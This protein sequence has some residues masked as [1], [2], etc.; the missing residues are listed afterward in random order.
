MV[1][2]RLSQREDALCQC[3]D[4]TEPGKSRCQSCADANNEANRRRRHKN[5]EVKWKT[6]NQNAERKGKPVRPN[7][8]HAAQIYFSCLQ[9]LCQPHNKAK[10]HLDFTDYSA[11]PEL[12]QPGPNVVTRMEL[13]ERVAVL[14]A[15]VAELKE[16]AEIGFWHKRCC[17]SPLRECQDDNEGD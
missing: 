4:P 5:P 7:C 12:F 2:V 17:A 10:G 13:E 3:G 11:H 15:E 14:E 1:Y 9:I 8:M 16:L 6:F